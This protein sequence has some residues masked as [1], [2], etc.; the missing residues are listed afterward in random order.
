[1]IAFVMLNP[2]TADAFADDPTITRCINFALRDGDY[3]EMVV[4]NLYAGRATKPDDLF[5]MRDPVGPDNERYWRALRESSSD[6]VCAW[7]ADKRAYDQAR[8]FLEFMGDRE[9]FCL[10]ISKQGCPRH[11]L[12]LRADSKMIPYTGKFQ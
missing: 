2:S 8:T 5:S 9:L 6:I 7:G 10:G 12:Y 11:P 1:M 4:M 3:D